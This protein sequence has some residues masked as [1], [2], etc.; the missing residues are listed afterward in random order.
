M[1]E[2]DY[3]GKLMQK[4]KTSQHLIPKVLQQTAAGA[5]PANTERVRSVYGGYVLRTRFSPNKR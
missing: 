5:L 1:Q 3:L 4:N 2:P